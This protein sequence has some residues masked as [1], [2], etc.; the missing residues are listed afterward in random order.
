MNELQYFKL[1]RKIAFF[2]VL[3]KRCRQF[4]FIYSKKLYLWQ[5]LDMS[6]VQL[7]SFLSLAIKHSESSIRI[8]WR[9]SVQPMPRINLRKVWAEDC[10]KETCLHFHNSLL[11]ASS[12]IYSTCTYG[13]TY[14]YV[15][16]YGESTI[17]GYC[18]PLIIF[19]VFFFFFTIGGFKLIEIFP[20]HFYIPW[21]IA[22]YNYNSVLGIYFHKYV[23][24]ERYKVQVI[25][26]K[27]RNSC[28]TH[29]P[30]SLWHL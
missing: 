3:A 20:K 2:K 10:V 5:S 21:N 17:I 24:K 16:T 28:C 26:I 19:F 23:I 1:I 12:D 18:P 13:D 15:H 22:L 7:P 4:Y 25:H 30:S 8:C 14:M 9:T 6:G 27:Q 29:K 11:K